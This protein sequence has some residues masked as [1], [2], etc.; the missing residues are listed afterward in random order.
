MDL[1]VKKYRLL[2]NMAAVYEGR[3]GTTKIGKFLESWRVEEI[4]NLD[5]D[6]WVPLIRDWGQA[7]CAWLISANLAALGLSGGDSSF[8]RTL[9]SEVIISS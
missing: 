9:I 7:F 3:R 4:S 8:R 2:G 6:W 1:E 5:F